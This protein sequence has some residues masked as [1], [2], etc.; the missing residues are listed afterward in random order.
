MAKVKQEKKVLWLTGFHS[1]V[2]KPLADFASSVLKL[3]KKAMDCSK[4]SLRKLSCFVEN[5]RK[6]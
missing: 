5:Q 1:N 4:D 3:L 6:P 2:G